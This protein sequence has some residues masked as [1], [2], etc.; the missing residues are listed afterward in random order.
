LQT[1]RCCGRARPNDGQPA[2]DARAV[3]APRRIMQCSAKAESTVHSSKDVQSSR[4]SRLAVV[5][6]GRVEGSRRAVGINVLK[7]PRPAPHQHG[8]APALIP[9]RT[10]L[11][12]CATTP[13]PGTAMMPYC[14][15]LLIPHHPH[16]CATGISLLVRFLW[17]QHD[18]PI[19]RP[20]KCGPLFPCRV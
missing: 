1:D 18:T 3:P 10:N 19:A 12:P 16:D 15:D 11:E 2:C 20:Y 14:P 6:S 8:D 5:R 4:R 13:Q 7:I 9:D 17:D